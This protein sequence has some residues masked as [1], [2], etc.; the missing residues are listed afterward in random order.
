MAV[1][2][3]AR[4]FIITTVLPHPTQGGA[5]LRA[6]NIVQALAALGPVSVF[7]LAN[8]PG[9]RPELKGLELWESA[10][11]FSHHDVGTRHQ[12]MWAAPSGSGDPSDAYYS[13]GIDRRLSEALHAEHPAVVIVDSLYP[14]GYLDTILGYQRSANGDVTVV[15]NSHNVEGPLAREIADAETVMPIRVLRKVLASST[16]TLEARVLEACDQVWTCSADD[17]ALFRTSYE[18][19]KPAT[20][21]PNVVDV[22]TYNDAYEAHTTGHPGSGMIFPAT[23]SYPPN[24]IGARFLLDRVVPLVPDVSVVLAGAGP[25]PGLIE[26]GAGLAHVTGAV[27]DMRPF[28]ADAALMV[29]PLFEGGGTRLKVLEGFAAGLPVVATPKAIE[30]LDVVDDVHLLIAEAPADF[31]AAIERVLQPAV[32][33]RLVAA[34]RA[35]VEASYSV[36]SL[37]P[38]LRSALDRRDL[39]Q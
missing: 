38:V 8:R 17:I 29:V 35:L 22:A 11:E 36:S 28:L 23:F 3:A 19:S 34:G 39:S 24:E 20:V 12:Q 33:A 2:E 4:S 10:P 25:S 1:G 15:H 30:G 6:W 7:A 26:A 31:A 9:P 5:D 32:C 13:D 27:P 37:G 16:S 14:G 18:C 21:V